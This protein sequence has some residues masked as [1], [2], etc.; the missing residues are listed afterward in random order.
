MMRSLRLCHTPAHRRRACI[1]AMPLRLPSA[2]RSVRVRG[3]MYVPSDSFG[4][5]SPERKAASILRTFFTFV[6]ARVVLAQLEG[7]GRGALG[8]YDS[9]AAAD[10]HH[11]LQ[12]VPMRD[13]DAWLE[14]LTRQ[15]TSL[16]LRLMEVRD[17]YC[18]EAFEWDQLQRLAKEEM[19]GANT[20]L[21]R[22]FAAASLAA[23]LE[24]EGADA[25]APAAASPRSAGWRSAALG[26]EGDSASSATTDNLPAGTSTGTSSS[27]STGIGTGTSSSAVASASAGA[28]A[29]DSIGMTTPGSDSGQCGDGNEAPGERSAAAA[30]AAGDADADAASAAQADGGGGGGASS[31]IPPSS[32]PTLPGAP[33][34]VE[35]PAGSADGAEGRG[36][37][38]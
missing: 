33:P 31:I 12:N 28:G 34:P 24:E 35:G 32:A 4:G 22:R 36:A 25:G 19:K 18:E 37:P 30:A 3:G 16:G 2:A 29:G 15:N 1:V 21:M 38:P 20:K 11:F 13:G 5:Q 10:L 17:S 6:A 14:Q 27:S 8:A 7:S 26:S 9:T 23:S